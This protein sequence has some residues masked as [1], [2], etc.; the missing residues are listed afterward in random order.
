MGLWD[1][2]T[3]RQKSGTG[4]PSSWLVDWVRGGSETASGERVGP[5]T[6][7]RVAAVWAC[8]RVRGEDIGKIPL[9]MYRRTAE[10]KERATEHPYYSL[11]RDAPN[12]FQTA[13]EFRQLMQTWV[14]LQGNAYAFKDYSST[15]VVTGLYPIC[16]DYVQVMV[17]EGS[18]YELFY[19]V[20]F[21]N[22]SEVIYPGELIL[23]LRGLSLDGL[24]GVSPITYHRE[25]IGMAMAAQ[26]Y[27]AGFFAGSAQP[28]GILQAPSLLSKEA[29]SAIRASW[30]KT[31][32]DNKRNY[33]ILDQGMTW[34]QMGMSNTDAQY[35]ETR[36]MQIREICR[37]YRV[38]P[39]KIQDLS[40]ATFSNIEHQGLE[41]VTDCLSSI[42]V[43]W[44]Q[45]LWRELLNEAERKAFFF[46]FMLD[47]L[48]RGDLAA[49]Y[50]A[51]ATGRNWG[52]LSA[53]DV[54][55]IENMNP[56]E[57]G[58]MYLQPQN[59]IEA[60]TSFEDQ[61]K[62]SAASKPQPPAKPPAGEKEARQIE[63]LTTGIARIRSAESQPVLH[64]Y[65]EAAKT[66][67]V[68]IEAPVS[69]NLPEN[70][71]Q[72]INVAA[73]EVNIEPSVVNVAAP[74]VEIEVPTPIVNVAA[75]NVRVDVATPA[76]KKR[77]T[78]TSVK[79]HDE[80]GRIVEFE[81]EDI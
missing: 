54:R 3:G 27:G 15:G 10:G 52:W 78:R 40:N 43:S 47:A 4:N 1:R 7:M 53:N 5:D 44:E 17:V 75:P 19:K 77:K 81:Q 68:Y 60:G 69:V 71:S 6:A 25:T 37:I 14:D 36:D 58:D 22:K 12:E 64:T 16:P 24:V 49:R 61:M 26:K 11:L 45:T 34:T 42:A 56:I 63:A 28:T 59:M 13:M 21:P 65:I 55:A 80:K 70:P 67:D 46:E 9:H 79:K 18:N 29:A 66:P 38:P 35:L 76:P 74:N 2:L 30:D 20:R 73:P 62:L 33:A 32:N 51:Y 8:I 50:A 39:H 48:T 57:D 72:T 31:F 23:H 41:Y